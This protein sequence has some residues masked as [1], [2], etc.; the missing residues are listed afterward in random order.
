[1]GIFD[2]ILMMAILAGTFWLLYNSLWKKKGYC[3]ECGGEGCAK[4]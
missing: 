2:I 3:Q 1:M 4:K